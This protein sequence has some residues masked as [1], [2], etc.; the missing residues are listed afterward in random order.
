MNATAAIRASIISTSGISLHTGRLSQLKEWPNFT[1]LDLERARNAES[2]AISIE[3][4]SYIEI[5]TG[6][7]RKSQL[8][9]MFTTFPFR[10]ATWLVAVGY[11]LGAILF[12]INSFFGL[13]PLIAPS[14]TFETESTIGLE[15]T[16]IVGLIFFLVAGAMDVR[17]APN[18][19]RDAAKI[20]QEKEQI[21]QPAILGSRDWA[22]VPK[23]GQ[24]SE[25]LAKNV[26]FQAALVQ[27]TGT[28]FLALAAITGFPGVMDPTT[29]YYMT[30]VYGPTF[31]GGLL[32]WI[33]NAMLLLGT[34]QDHW[35]VAKPRT[36]GWHAALQSTGGGFLF[37]MIGVFLLA[38]MT[39]AAAWVTLIGSWMFMIGCILGWYI[40][41]AVC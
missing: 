19:N 21:H 17:S 41:M 25:L 14:L 7:A 8:G 39:L 34:E 4:G 28:I 12:V 9:R 6:K 16:L 27:L 2:D 15:T 20:A 23:Q 5:E 37:M 1:S 33:A 32:F 13:L 36:V 30:F 10:D 31:V 18:A 22:K 26:S 24:Y 11:V 38:G 40:T 35:W 29:T 3:N